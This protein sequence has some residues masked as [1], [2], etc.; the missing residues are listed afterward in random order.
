MVVVAP[1]AG[2][3]ADAWGIRPALVVA[4]VTFALVTIGLAATPFRTARAPD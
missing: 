2:L 4:A 1:A 3:L